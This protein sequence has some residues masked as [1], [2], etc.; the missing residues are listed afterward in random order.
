MSPRIAI[1]S[2]AIALSGCVSLLPETPPPPPRYT[3]TAPSVTI[4]GER[5]R[6]GLAIAPPTAV[7]ALDTAAVAIGR[8]P[9]RL[10]YHPDLEW[11]DRAP[12]LVHQL[13]IRAFE[14][15]EAFAFVARRGEAGGAR[16]VLRTDL[17]Q[18]EIAD[19]P[20]REAVVILRAGL[21]DL[22]AGEI[23]ASRTIEGRAP[24]AAGGEA[25]ISAFDGAS[26]EALKELVAFAVEA[27]GAGGN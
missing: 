23:I 10:E 17:R 4:E 3:L 22:A 27:A 9:Y 24:V 7:S 26:D 25:L 12:R 21:Y 6:E 19:A 5:I 14:D 13:M 11:S 20:S 8:G 16:Y 15:A 1:L 2:A 18:F